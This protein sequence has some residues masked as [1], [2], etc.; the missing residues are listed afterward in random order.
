METGL[1]SRD[2]EN[3]AAV[4]TSQAKMRAAGRRFFTAHAMPQES[5]PPP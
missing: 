2:A 1:A 4:S 5:P 3:G